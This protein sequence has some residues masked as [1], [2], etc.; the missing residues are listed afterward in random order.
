MG[1]LNVP[2][3]NAETGL[4]MGAEPG[5]TA[6]AVE[7]VRPH[8]DKPLIVK[9]TPNAADPAAVAVAARDAGA[10]ETALIAGTGH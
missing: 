1:G 5:E 6:R 3:P 9:L 7:H 2:C 10:L 4:V 8:S